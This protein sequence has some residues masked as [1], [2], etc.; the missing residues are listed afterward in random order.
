MSDL[1]QLSIRKEKWFELLEFTPHEG[2]QPLF[3]SGARFK[4]Y[5]CGRRWGKSLSAARWA[6]LK[7]LIPGSRGW[8]VANTYD[9]TRKVIREIYTDMVVKFMKP[10]GMKLIRDI[11]SGPILMEF[12]W[13]STVE[14]KSC[15]QPNSLLGEGLDWIVFDESAKAKQRIWEY[16]LRPTLTDR[17]GE[18]LFITTPNGYNWVYDLWKRGNDP[19]FPEWESRSSPSWDNPHLPMEDIEEARRTLSDAAFR[20]EY[21]AE[22]TIYTG[23]VYK[24]FD[25]DVHV[26]PQEE[27]FIDPNWRKFRAI[28]FGYENPFVCL[29]IA[30]DEMDRVIVYDEYYERHRTVEQHARHLRKDETRYEYT[31]CDPSGASS[32]ATL[33]ENGIPTIALRS[34]VI[35]GLEQVRRTLRPREDGS[36]GF[37][38]S[39]KCVNTIQEFNL[40]RY[41]DTDYKTSEDP[42]KDNDHSMDALR[43]FIVNWKRGYATQRTGK[44]A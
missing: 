27:L 10:G 11:Q 40:Y 33:L 15:D 20:Q 37:L 24:E 1:K 6:E 2:E 34:E 19:D 17:N 22:F 26:V 16:Y 35:Q 25:E 36:P 12:P 23:Q 18:I 43:Y 42:I 9:L 41:P 30:L 7:I 38:V 13:G 39:S 44:Y 29:Y 4:V 28:D 3:D 5:V 32:R 21:G 8:V 31:V 14:G